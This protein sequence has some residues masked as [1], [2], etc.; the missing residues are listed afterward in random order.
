MTILQVNTIKPHE[1]YQEYLAL[2]KKHKMNLIIE[3]PKLPEDG[4][5][6]QRLRKHI[7]R[8]QKCASVANRVCIL[9]PD[10]NS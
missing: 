1:P 7:P 6:S 2:I 10:N 8:V 5:T 3:P 9:A 4:E